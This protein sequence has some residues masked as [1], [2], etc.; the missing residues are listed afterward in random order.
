MNPDETDF[1]KGVAAP[2]RRALVA[3]GY[4]ELRQL[5]GVPAA[6]LSRLHGMGQKALRVL[7]AALEEQGMS[8]G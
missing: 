1:P 3:A 6:E 4:I 5:D 8:L 7:Q 2:A